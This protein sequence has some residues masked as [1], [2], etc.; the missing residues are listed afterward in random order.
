V[1]TVAGCW[2]GR[3]RTGAVPTAGRAGRAGC[4]PSPNKGSAHPAL[5]GLP[6][7]RNRSACLP[8][9]RAFLM[10]VP[11]SWAWLAGVRGQ[12]AASAFRPS[13][14]HSWRTVLNKP[15]HKL[16]GRNRYSP[17]AWKLHWL[18]PLPFFKRHLHRPPHHCRHASG[19]STARY[20][21]GAP[22]Q[23]WAGSGSP[24]LDV[25]SQ[26][27]PPPPGARLSSCLPA[28]QCPH[29]C[30]RACAC[31]AAKGVPP[32]R[33]PIQAEACVPGAQLAQGFCRCAHHPVRRPPT[34][35][36]QLL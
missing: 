3:Q 8:H 19:Y 11:S 1:N 18:G 9:G 16:C 23:P 13:M 2:P 25:P 27:G 24:G 5:S 4:P 6:H 35:Q 26:A 28:L 31:A 36:P 33:P 14:F 21:S 20:A 12:L 34:Q 10:G 29:T 32:H 15:V 22:R 30:A 17:A 7:F